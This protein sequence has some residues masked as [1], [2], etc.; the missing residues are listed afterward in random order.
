MTDQTSR[1][2]LNRIARRELARRCR[3]FIETNGPDMFAKYEAAARERH[4][5][6]TSRVNVMI[7]QLC[8]EQVRDQHEYLY[9]EMRAEARW[10]HIGQHEEQQRIQA[11][12][13]AAQ[14]A[15]QVQLEDSSR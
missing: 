5:D 7:T 10:E 12:L 3:E 4:G 6:D 11:E 2:E 14:A 15:A 9:A 8:K 1:S 13:A